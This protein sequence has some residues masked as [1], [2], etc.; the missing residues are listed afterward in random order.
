[1]KNI[2]ELRSVKVGKYLCIKDTGGKKHVCCLTWLNEN[3]KVEWHRISLKLANVL[4]K[5][6]LDF[7]ID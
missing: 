6:G 1:M 7:T 3:N 4:I 2:S 5:S